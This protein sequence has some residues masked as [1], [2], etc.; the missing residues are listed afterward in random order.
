MCLYIYVLLLNEL[1]QRGP[2]SIE[3]PQ[4]FTVPCLAQTLPQEQNASC[5][6][7]HL[8]NSSCR[9]LQTRAV[10]VG[11]FVHLFPSCPRQS[12]RQED[13][14]IRVCHWPSRTVFL[15][16]FSELCSVWA[17]TTQIGP[18]WVSMCFQQLLSQCS[19]F[20]GYLPSCWSS[21]SM[22]KMKFCIFY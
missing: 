22:L 3:A 12:R 13:L 16:V 7:T 1:R 17:A 15:L 8:H 14:S 4:A 9:R 11:A 10:L 6:V 20:Q 2:G 18:Q 19:C 5:D 21:P